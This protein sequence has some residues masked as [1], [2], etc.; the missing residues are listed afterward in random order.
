MVARRVI[1][2]LQIPNKLWHSAVCK[3]VA[4]LWF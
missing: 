4:H 3:Q 2:L 1:I